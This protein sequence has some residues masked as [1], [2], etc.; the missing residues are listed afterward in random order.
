MIFLNIQDKNFAR[1]RIQ[2]WIRQLNKKKKGMKRHLSKQK[3]KLI[4]RITFY[5]QVLQ[6]LQQYEGDVPYGNENN[7]PVFTED[8]IFYISMILGMR[9]CYERMKQLSEIR[10]TEDEKLHADLQKLLRRVLELDLTLFVNYQNLNWFNNRIDLISSSVESMI[11]PLLYEC[12]NDDGLNKYQIWIKN[13]F[14]SFELLCDYE[15]WRRENFH[16]NKWML[17]CPAQCTCYIEK[18]EKMIYTI[19]CRNVFFDHYEHRHHP[20]P[21]SYWFNKADSSFRRDN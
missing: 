1:F 21:R 3:T 18:V 13:L 8:E 16:N 14:S 20:P 4:N 7:E 12:F 10:F 15:R 9:G 5:K 2:Y 17:C 19:I 6:K 11:K